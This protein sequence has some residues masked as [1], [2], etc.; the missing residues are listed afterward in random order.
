VILTQQDGDLLRGIVRKVHFAYVE[1]KHGKGF[2][3]DKECDKLI[4]S[5]G[6]EVAERMI[7]FGIDK[8]L[9]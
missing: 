2:V 6:P 7:R 8:G 3:S 5:L 4:D 9:R 1:K